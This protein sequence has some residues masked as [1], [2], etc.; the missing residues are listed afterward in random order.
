MPVE[1]ERRFLVLDPCAA[2]GARVAAFSHITQGYFGHVDGLRVR[3]RVVCGAYDECTAFLTFKG[4][5]RGICRL[6]YEY[7]LDVARAWR[8]LDCLPPLE[9]IQKTR[10]RVP[11]RDGL[12]W[13]VDQFEGPNQ[14]L[15]IAE[16]ELSHP[17]QKIALPSWAGE[18]ITFD[19]RYGNSQLARAPMPLSTTIGGGQWRASNTLRPVPCPDVREL[20]P[21]ETL[22][23]AAS[24]P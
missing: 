14:G 10:H 15:F 19:P 21:F 23:D 5:R 8:A 2:M 20:V 17:H 18:E 13:S 22:L 16:V 24:E 1:I 7:P 6:E 4:A 11:H 12:E 9:I 3:V